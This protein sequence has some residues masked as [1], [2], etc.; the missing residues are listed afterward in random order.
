MR[1]WRAGPLRGQ[2]ACAV[3]FCFC[4]AALAGSCVAVG[5]RVQQRVQQRWPERG[6]IRAVVRAAFV[7]ALRG[8][9]SGHS[10]TNPPGNRNGHCPLRHTAVTFGARPSTEG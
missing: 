8:A 3:P 10:N 4:V 2:R 1:G 9:Q 7:C 5:L 6:C